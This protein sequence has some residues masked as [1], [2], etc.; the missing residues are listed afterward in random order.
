MKPAATLLL[1]VAVDK[2]GHPTC[3]AA[4]STDQRRRGCAQASDDFV[5]NDRKERCGL[6]SG[7]LRRV[8]SKAVQKAP[9]PA[10]Q[11]DIKRCFVGLSTAV[12]SSAT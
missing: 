6:T 8:V 5:A 11:P 3:T 12:F 9:A 2:S 4:G 1:P 10:P 7:Q